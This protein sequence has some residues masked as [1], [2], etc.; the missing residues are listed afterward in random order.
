MNVNPAPN[1]GTWGSLH[2][3]LHRPPLPVNP[4]MFPGLMYVDALEAY[5]AL[6][7]YANYTMDQCQGNCT[8]IEEVGTLGLS[9]L[10]MLRPK[11]KTLFLG[12]PDPP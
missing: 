10:C 2:H 1:N 8:S 5:N 11:N 12:L 3:L 4:T 6:G 9:T 7:N